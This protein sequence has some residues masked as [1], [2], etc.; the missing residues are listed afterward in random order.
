MQDNVAG[1]PYGVYVAD[2]RVVSPHGRCIALACPGVGTV[3]ARSSLARRDTRNHEHGRRCREE[4][5]RREV[6]VRPR[7]RIRQKGRRS[8]PFS[9]VWPAPQRTKEAEAAAVMLT[10]QEERPEPPDR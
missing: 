2:R 3:H 8:A 10:T 6:A 4:A 5:E 7:L 9:M 1:L